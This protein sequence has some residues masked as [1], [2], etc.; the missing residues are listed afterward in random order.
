[1]NHQCPI[2]GNGRGSLGLKCFEGRKRRRIVTRRQ[3]LSGSE[4]H[5]KEDINRSDRRKGA[6]IHEV[7]LALAR[8]N[9]HLG[10]SPPRHERV[11]QINR[12]EL[13]GG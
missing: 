11:P 10:A 5:Q 12:P 8:T 4:P 9:H 3:R 1:M 6:T 2:N 7:S 13:T